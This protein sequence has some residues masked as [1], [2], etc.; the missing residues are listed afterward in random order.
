MA[1]LRFIAL[2]EKYLNIFYRNAFLKINVN[3]GEIK[4]R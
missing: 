3:Y 2:E 1:Y 4:R